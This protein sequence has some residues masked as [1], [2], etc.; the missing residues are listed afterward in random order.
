MGGPIDIAQRKWQWVIHD[1]DHDHLVTKVRCIDLPDNDWGD[2]SCRRAVDSSSYG[3]KFGDMMQ[4]T[5]KRMT[6]WNGH[7]QPMF[8]FSDLFWPRVLS[9]SECLVQFYNV[10][11]QYGLNIATQPWYGI[12]SWWCH[13]IFLITG[14]CEGNPLVISGF[15][16]QRANNAE[17]WYSLW[18]LPEK[19][20][21]KQVSCC[22]FEIAWCSYDFTVILQLQKE[23]LILLWTNSRAM[24]CL[25]LEI[26]QVIIKAH[27]VCQIHFWFTWCQ[28]SRKVGE[29]FSAFHQKFAPT[30]WVIICFGN[31]FSLT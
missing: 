9:F 6:I 22:W 30:N 12:H 5:M 3:L 2:F 14:L 7:A 31:S 4:C 23:E 19:L 15:P 24:V 27:G 18:C 8:P 29:L 20:F 10:M 17:L 26:D 28:I 13:D 11:I 25:L 21:N 16:L 1:H